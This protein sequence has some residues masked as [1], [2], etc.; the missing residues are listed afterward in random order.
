MMGSR[1]SF[2]PNHFPRVSYML[3]YQ[4]FLHLPRGCSAGR[5]MLPLLYPSWVM[6][7]PSPVL[8]FFLRARMSLSQTPRRLASPTVS[9]GR[10][11]NAQS[12]LC[13]LLLRDVFGG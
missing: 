3:A 11:G 9:R 7:G 12:A 6:P 10:R 4:S 1:I 5:L 8:L 2:P 13:A